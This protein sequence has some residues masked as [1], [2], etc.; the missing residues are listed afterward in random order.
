MVEITCTAMA[1]EQHEQPYWWIEKNGTYELCTSPLF[2]IVNSFQVSSCKWT[3]VLTIMN[4]SQITSGNYYCGFGDHVTNKT[5]LV[6]GVNQNYIA[7]NN[8]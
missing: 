6:Q 4:F 8:R 1:V 5:L 2:S 7:P 3:T